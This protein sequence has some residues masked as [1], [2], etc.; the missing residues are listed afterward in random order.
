M[1]LPL[2]LVISGDGFELTAA[3]RWDHA[4]H[5]GFTCGLPDGMDGVSREPVAAKR[6]GYK[7]VFWHTATSKWAVSIWVDGRNLHVGSFDTIPEAV[8]A[9]DIWMIDHGM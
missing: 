2:T 5:P 3:A 1:T 9:R 6:S 4:P 8:A 7:Y